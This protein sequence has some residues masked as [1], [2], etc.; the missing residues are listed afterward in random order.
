MSASHRVQDSHDAEAEL[1]GTGLALTRILLDMLD[2]E[3]SLMLARDVRALEDMVGRKQQLV[4]DLKRIEPLLLD[5][6]RAE[7]PIDTDSELGQLRALMVEGRDKNRRNQTVAITGMRN[8][9]QSLSLLR[10]ML[11]LDDL[12]LY[13]A[14]GAVLVRREKRRLGQL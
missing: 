13:D 11:N 5:R 3:L 9:N 7:S 12:A 1:I 10:S 4:D 2:D 6:L 14:E 8:A